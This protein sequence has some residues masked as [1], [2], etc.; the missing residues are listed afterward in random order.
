MIA[1][2]S[3]LFVVDSVSG[4]GSE[5]FFVPKVVPLATKLENV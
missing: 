1:E 3:F 2:Q 4:R 5:C